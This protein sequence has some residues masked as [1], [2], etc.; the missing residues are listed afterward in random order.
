M[1]DFRQ[2]RKKETSCA[3]TLP[4][5]PPHHFDARQPA[6][7]RIG[8]ENIVNT[9]ERPARHLLQNLFDR[10]RDSRERQPAV[11]KGSH[12]DLV[13]GIQCAGH[14]PSLAKRHPGQFEAAE[15][16]RRNFLE[17]KSA[18]RNPIHRTIIGC[19]SLRIS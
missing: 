18:Q 3:A 11:E 7:F 10:L 13:R 8:G 17:V 9:A 5:G 14:R 4:P 12:R 6:G 19:D 1:A 16:S 2:R 15:F